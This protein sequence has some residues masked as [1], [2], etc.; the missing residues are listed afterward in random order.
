MVVRQ[1]MLLV[2]AGIVLGIGGSLAL[3]TLI[4]TLLYE[5]R[6][7]DP[8]SSIAAALVLGIV[9]FFA[10]YVPARR[11]TRVDPVTALRYE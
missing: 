6:A 4:S 2:L 7:T 9:A 5:I 3:S 11:A 8:L 1:G 10:C